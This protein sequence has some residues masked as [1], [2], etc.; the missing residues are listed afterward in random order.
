MHA[1]TY[2]EIVISFLVAG[3]V[4]G[5]PVWASGRANTRRGAETLTNRNGITWRFQATH[6]TQRGHL[7][8]DFIGWCL[9]CWATMDDD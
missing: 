6:G 2:L 4:Y 1:M 5:G 7:P 9:Q 3:A 8:S